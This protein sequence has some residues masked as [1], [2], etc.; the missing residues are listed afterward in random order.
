MTSVANAFA[1]GLLLPLHVLNTRTAT[2]QSTGVDLLDYEGVATIT[3]D[4][5]A[6][7]GTTPTNAVTFDESDD[8]STWS[9]IPAAEFME[10][11]N[12]TGLTTVASQQVRHINVSERKR[13][14][15]EVHTI[16]G[17]T[18]SYTFSVSM[19]AQKKYS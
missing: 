6:G 4:S 11:T 19:I 10:G 18:P 5:A 17:T 9:A 16:T 7:T 8:N 2:G 3:L 12:F 1:K 15:R 14:I 13:Y